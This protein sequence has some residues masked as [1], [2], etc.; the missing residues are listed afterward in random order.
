MKLETKE[1]K[2]IQKNLRRIGLKIVSEAKKRCP[3]DT[4]R[5]RNSIHSDLTSDGFGIRVG[6]NVNYAPDVEFG[7]KP[8]TIKPK[9]SEALRWED[10]N[11]EH[12]AK[13]VEHP[14]TEAQPFLRPAIDKVLNNTKKL[15]E[16]K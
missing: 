8:H 13:K 10:E 2:K 14:G 7:T 12:F 4:G 9:D 15:N 1:R 3:V 16:V 11:G 6:T 5:L